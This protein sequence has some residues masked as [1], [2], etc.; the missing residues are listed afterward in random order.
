MALKNF[1]GLG[2]VGAFEKPIEFEY[3]PLGL[4][5]F[6]QPLAQMQQRYDL[7][8]QSI[9]ESKF[10]ID[11]LDPH[12]TRASELASKLEQDKNDILNELARTG[13][14]RQAAKALNKLNKFYNEDP[15]I[16][17]YRTN[18][19]FR[20]EDLA[21]QQKRVDE[22][23]ITQIDLDKEAFMTADKFA[24]KVAQNP[25]NRETKSGPNI[26]KLTIERN[27]EDDIFELATQLAKGTPL[28]TDEQF[29]K[30]AAELGI[31]AEA[32]KVTS[33]R[34]ELGQTSGELFRLLNQSKNFKHFIENRAEREFYAATTP[35]SP[36]YEPRFE[37]GVINKMLDELQ[38]GIDTEKDPEKKKELEES[39]DLFNARLQKAIDAGDITPLA[40]QVYMSDVAAET[41]KGISEGAADLY[42]VLSTKLDIKELASSGAGRELNKNIDS[43]TTTTQ[44]IPRLPKDIKESE[45]SVMPGGAVSDTKVQEQI[46]NDQQE[47]GQRMLETAESTKE[48]QT[49]TKSLDKYEDLTIY[50]P[51]GVEKG[52]VSELPIFKKIKTT[53]K[54]IEP[55]YNDIVQTND[56][57]KERVEN[58]NTLEKR[59]KEINNKLGSSSS[60]DIS[61]GE[62]TALRAELREINEEISNQE[63]V[64]SGKTAY[65]EFQLSDQIKNISDPATKEKYTKALENGGVTAV[66]DELKFDLEVGISGMSDGIAS[67]LK[68]LETASTREGFYPTEEGGTK[69]AQQLYWEESSNIE[70]VLDNTYKSNEKEILKLSPLMQAFNTWKGDVIVAQV[71]STYQVVM[72][73]NLNKLTNG[74]SKILAE[75]LVL[76]NSGYGKPERVIYNPGTG[77]INEELTS[78]EETMLRDQNLNLDIEKD[79]D[80]NSMKLQGIAEGPSGEEYIIVTLDRNT[81]DQDV[82]I[83]EATKGKA[84]LTSK[85]RG[86]IEKAIKTG[87]LD[88]LSEYEQSIAKEVITN[89]KNTPKE[90]TVGVKGSS[91]NLVK[92]AAENTLDGIKNAIATDND[93]NVDKWL[94]TYSNLAVITSNNKRD[95]NELA[96]TLNNI[97]TS[98]NTKDYVYEA[99]HTANDL[100]NGTTEEYAIQY[101]GT[102]KGSPINAHIF[103][104]IRDSET[105]ELLTSNHVNTEVLTATTPQ[106]LFK[107]NLMYGVGNEEDALR[108]KQNQ[109]YVP[110]FQY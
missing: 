97:I 79:Y 43:Y 68:S 54:K 63:K 98:G 37:E 84:T 18:K 14:S 69:S 88:E 35:N 22:N 42:D 86:E 2:T 83:T 24:K 67:S 104:I 34:R 12:D 61:S 8:E 3:K 107:L 48:L 77:K 90:I 28:Q 71:P 58:I 32:I 82:L 47:L 16:V 93:R 31:D 60:T 110:S 57:L 101:Q 26:E 78:E 50:Q 89:L 40:H 72:D 19:K 41:I 76:N 74:E 27:I 91:I 59:R 92:A 38:L 53:N 95:Y 9:D 4:E 106:I 55:V 11:S 80:P 65:L 29:L 99:A 62:K 25:F 23:E 15:E 17:N 87:N 10:G 103:K 45:A 102:G 21:N 13:N 108:D 75:H 81:L 73:D 70:Q 7:T 96:V 109:V 33:Q 6:A 52:T 85:S 30:V 44:A 51:N 94:T 64:I 5:A 56:Y 66:L 20:Q 105:G 1:K 36:W 100:G 49:T 46:Y 39:R